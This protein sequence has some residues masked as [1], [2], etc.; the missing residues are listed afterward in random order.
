[1]NKLRLLSILEGT[2]LILLL[3]IAVPLKR[4]FEMPEAVS[5]IGPIHGGLFIAFT[6]VLIFAVFKWNLKVSHAIIGFIASLIPFGSY[7][8]KAKILNKYES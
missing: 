2:S 5:I 7:L 4:I 8:F 1:M 6:L 3:L